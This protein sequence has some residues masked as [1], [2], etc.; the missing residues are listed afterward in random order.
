MYSHEIVI[1]I[2]D[3]GRQIR[4]GEGWKHPTCLYFPTFPRHH[5][6]KMSKRNGNWK[7]PSLYSSGKSRPVTITT[8]LRPKYSLKAELKWEKDKPNIHRNICTYLKSRIS[9]TYY[10]AG[11]PH[12]GLI[13]GTENQVCNL[14]N[15]RDPWSLLPETSFSLNIHSHP[16]FIIINWAVMPVTSNLAQLLVLAPQLCLFLRSSG[17]HGTKIRIVIQRILN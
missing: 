8:S 17:E 2:L 7:T 1:R 10:P 12:A 13:H 4:V 15:G 5:H 16:I 11:S 9:S 3:T 14:L 6:H